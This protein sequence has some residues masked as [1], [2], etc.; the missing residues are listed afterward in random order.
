[1]CLPSVGLREGSLEAKSQQIT[2]Q[3]NLAGTRPRAAPGFSAKH[4]LTAPL[5]PLKRS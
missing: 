1:M 4:P 2:L 5:C 3:L